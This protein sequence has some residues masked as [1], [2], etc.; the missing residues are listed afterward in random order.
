MKLPAFCM[1]Q[2]TKNH[3][4]VNKIEQKMYKANSCRIASVC[5]AGKFYASN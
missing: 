2:G 1:Q 4:E 3:M 5:Y